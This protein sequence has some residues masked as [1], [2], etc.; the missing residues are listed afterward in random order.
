ME[1]KASIVS[2][3]YSDGAKKLS[4]PLYGGSYLSSGA[5]ST[6]VRTESLLAIVVENPS[7]VRTCL[8]LT[9]YTHMLQF[10]GS[11]NHATPLTSTLFYL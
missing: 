9:A 2:S 6:T 3:N 4:R 5:E 1:T 11:Q 10:T 8:K 7:T